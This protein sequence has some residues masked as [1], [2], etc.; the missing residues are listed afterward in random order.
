MEFT[1]SGD[2]QYLEITKIYRNSMLDLKEMK[3]LQNEVYTEWWLKS[4]LPLC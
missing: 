3:E 2:D 4:C 1:V